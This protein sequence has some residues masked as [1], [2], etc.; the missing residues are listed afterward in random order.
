MVIQAQL[1]LGEWLEGARL[2]VTVFSGFPYLVAVGE[3][4]PPWVR[5]DSF[6]PCI[7]WRRSVRKEE[8]ATSSCEPGAP[9]RKY[10]T[11]ASNAVWLKK[12]IMDY[13]QLCMP[14]E[15]R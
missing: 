7:S 15:S 13:N 8:E 6:E 14:M 4:C 1:P 11:G 12:T 10:A 9:F 5:P 3:Y 2:S